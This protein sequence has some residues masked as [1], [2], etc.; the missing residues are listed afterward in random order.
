MLE[1]T[2]AQPGNER[3]ADRPEKPTPNVEVTIPLNYLSNF[4]R[5]L[6]LPLINCAI[7]FDLSCTKDCVQIEHHN[8]IRGVNVMIASNK[9]YV[10]VAS[11]SINDRNQR[12]S[13]VITQRKNN[14]LDYLID[15]SFRSINRFYNLSLKNGD[16]D[17]TR[18]YFDEYY[19]PLI[20]IKDFDEL[21]DNKSF[22]DQPV[23]KNKRRMK[24]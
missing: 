15:H 21:I 3:D 22:F 23:K 14:N 7:E 13:E 19:M 12:R 18:N 20:E 6:D 2:E 24:N 11:L 16:D 9:L 1:K 17:P 5:F 10:P 4:W 8:N